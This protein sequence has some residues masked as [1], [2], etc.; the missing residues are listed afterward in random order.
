M[1]IILR[2]TVPAPLQAADTIQKLLGILALKLRH[3]KHI[4]ITLQLEMLV[5]DY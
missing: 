5:G 1:G 2:D 4:K 3:K